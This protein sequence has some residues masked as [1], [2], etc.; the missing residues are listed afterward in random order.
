M[1]SPTIVVIATKQL[2]S[3]VTG[4]THGH[5]LPRELGKEGGRD[6]RRISERLIV[7]DRHPG[8][9]GQQIGRC[10]VEV[11]VICSELSR[12]CSRVVGFVVARLP[13]SDGERSHRPTTLGLHQSDNRGRIDATG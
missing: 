1:P 11:G 4:K 6:L 8:N 5:V 10:D 13:K 7:Y 3:T 2:V 9:H 12:Y